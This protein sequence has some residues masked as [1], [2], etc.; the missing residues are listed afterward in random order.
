LLLVRFKTL[1][2]E[3]RHAEQEAIVEKQMEE[4]STGRYALSE[5]SQRASERDDH[6]IDGLAPPSKRAPAGRRT[7]K[8]SDAPADGGAC[9]TADA[10]TS[11]A[12]KRC[13]SFSDVENESSSG[14]GANRRR[15]SRHKSA[16][17]KIHEKTTEVLAQQSAQYLNFLLG[18][19][20]VKSIPRPK[21]ALCA[22]SL[23]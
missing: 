13:C 12:A 18:S 9:G 7:A 19:S 22:C 20:H 10:D 1:F 15:F 4:L 6:G 21:R 16:R 17:T 8:V 14:G 5:R 11:G 3:M 23:A 2:E